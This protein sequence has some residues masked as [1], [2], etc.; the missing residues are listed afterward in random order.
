MDYEV[1][2]GLEV[3]VQVRTD[4]KMF[5]RCPNRYDAEPNTLVCPICLGYP[6]VLP[7]P[8]E[9][10]I[11][12]T[13][14]A[15]MMCNCQLAPYSK[16]DRK[17]YFYPDMPK[18]Y[19]TSQYDLPLCGPGHLRIEG[20]ALTGDI[21]PKDIGITRIHLEED[22]GKLTHF[23]QVSGVDYNRAGKPLM[24]CVS[25]PDIR[26]AEEAYAYLTALKQVMQYAEISDCDMEKGQMRC[27]VNISVRWAGE[28]E[29][30]DKTELKNLNSFKSVHRAINY[31]IE[32]QLDILYEGGEF[33]QET[34][35]WDD[36]L[37]QT[38]FQ[39]AK[40]SSEDYR[41]FPCPDLMPM[42]I[43][44]EMLADIR[45]HAPESP[46]ARRDRFVADHGLP[47]YDAQV[48]TLD[49]ATAD[50]FEATVNAGAPAKQAS[51]WIMTDLMRLVSDSDHGFERLQLSPDS[52][53]TLIGM[54][55]DKKISHKQAKQVLSELFAG[56]GTDP[57]AIA[58]D[59]GL[60][61]VSDT[62]AIAEFV[63]QAIE[64]NPGPAQEFRD[65]ND[66]AL[67]FLVGQVMRFSRGKANPQLAIQAIKE[68]LGD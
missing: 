21:E 37:G 1:I 38:I 6:G 13:L 46:A 47:E 65:G 15:G 66:K 16:F 63:Q 68:E 54:I 64:A 45:Q 24:E 55:D 12:K 67:N 36:D 62:G 53:A 4:M 41:Y 3:H 52:L 22:T 34:R 20:K 10:A 31:E 58:K 7:V 18:N 9:E 23:G 17:S 50:F 44:D 30:N 29:F 59:K 28:D 56:N 8:N 60:V 26:S 27:D 35:G 61:Q 2:I 51:N 25:E 42:E 14:L 48:L 39:R 11:R 32:R 49:K 57:E 40:E 5:C 33:R 43:T 19:Q